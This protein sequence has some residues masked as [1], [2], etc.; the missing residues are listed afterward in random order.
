MTFALLHLIKYSINLCFVPEI[1][2]FPRERVFFAGI[3]GKLI[4]NF[5]S[6]GKSQVEMRYF[7]EL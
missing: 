5:Q 7:I 1:G 6:N 4:C 3:I 2:G